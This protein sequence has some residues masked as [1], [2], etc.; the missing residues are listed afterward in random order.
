MRRRLVWCLGLGGC[1]IYGSWTKL[2]RGWVCLK[3]NK[4]IMLGPAYS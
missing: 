2:D 1:P 3:L 4:W